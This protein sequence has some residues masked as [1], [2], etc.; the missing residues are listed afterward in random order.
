MPGL[1]LGLTGPRIGRNGSSLSI[2][3][4]SYGSSLDSSVHIGAISHLLNALGPF[5]KTLAENRNDG[6]NFVCSMGDLVELCLFLCDH[7][8]NLGYAK[9]TRMH[10]KF[11]FLF[12]VVDH[13]KFA[14]K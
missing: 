11:C 2:D 5:F 13:T 10:G 14:S 8:D 9:Q 4:I 6:A 12:T 7:A 3:R 1:F